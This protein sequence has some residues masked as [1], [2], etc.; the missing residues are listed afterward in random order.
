VTGLPYRTGVVYPALADPAGLARFA[1]RVEE[2]GFDTLWVIEDCFLSGGLTMAATALA[3]TESIGVGVG[4]LPVSV[5]NPAIA[6]ME[7]ATLA[8]MHPGRFEATLGHGVAAWMQ[9]VG[10]LPAKRLAALGETATAIRALL[11]GET[12]TVS[13]TYVKLSQVALE[14]A[15]RAAPPVLIGTTGPKG[16]AVAGRHADGILLP[17][18]CGPPFVEWAI[19]QTASSTPRCV[20]YSWFSI[21]DDPVRARGRLL[22]AID[23]WLDTDLFPHPRRAAGAGDPPPPGDPARLA[24]AD[25]IS[26][27][28]DAEAC[29][30]AVR[31]LAAAGADT[32]V[33]AAPEVE[34]EPQLERFAREVMPL[35]KG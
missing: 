19:G 8:R 18:G 1:V 32:I 30:E 21:D 22:P 35:L 34:L 9:Q 24:L 33:L 17:E 27:C 31:R 10:A 29:A 28:G 3:L 13:G 25:A 5:R 4:L 26:V 7:I 16:L 12:V 11:A 23:H 14:H 2:L 6:A 20:V 15:P